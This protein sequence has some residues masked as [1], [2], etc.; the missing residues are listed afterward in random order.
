MFAS[1][2]DPYVITVGNSEQRGKKES[3]KE[4]ERNESAREKEEKESVREKEDVMKNQEEKVFNFTQ[5]SSGVGQFIFQHSE[6]KM[7]AKTTEKCIPMVTKVRALY[8]FT[9]TLN[10]E[11][12][13]TDSE[14]EKPDSER[15]QEASER[16]KHIS[17]VG[18]LSPHVVLPL[19]SMRHSGPLRLVKES[20]VKWHEKKLRAVWRGAANGHEENFDRCHLV[21]KY[22]GWEEGGSGSSSSSSDSGSRGSGNEVEIDVGFSRRNNVRKNA[23][24]SLFLPLLKGLRN[25]P[26]HAAIK[27]VDTELLLS[28]KQDTSTL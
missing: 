16:E 22:A 8:S 7:H 10:R 9:P 3:D 25:S 26:S 27:E 12:E 14:R 15:E 6:V 5:D 18:S 21:M 1:C 13:K 19:N 23:C 11:G 28:G 17:Y 24:A 20:D 4:K 2:R